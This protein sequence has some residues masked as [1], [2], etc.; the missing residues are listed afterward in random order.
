MTPA[1]SSRVL[2]L[3]VCCRR[4]INTFRGVRRWPIIELGGQ[5]GQRD[6]SAARR[7]GNRLRNRDGGPFERLLRIS[8]R[9]CVCL[10]CR[11]HR[12]LANVSQFTLAKYIANK[13]IIAIAFHSTCKCQ[14]WAIYFEQG[15]I[16]ARLKMDNAS[17]CEKEVQIR[18][19]TRIQMD[20]CVC[21]SV[22]YMITG[23]I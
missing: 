9:E 4:L 5:W 11:R 18:T 8:G 6:G 17:A 7:D 23:S 10:P 21:C 15:D 22:R 3:I 2:D 19:R 12:R 1:Y 16:A 13:L 20:G 14:N